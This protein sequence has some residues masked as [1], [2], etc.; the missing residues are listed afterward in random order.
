MEFEV[1]GA[2]RLWRC[3]TQRNHGAQTGAFAQAWR[4]NDSWA[5]LDHFRRNKPVE[6]ANDYGALFGME[7]N[8]HALFYIHIFDIGNCETH[9]G[10]V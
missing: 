3:S 5:A 2:N 8:S 7:L 6:V 1:V 4:H 9:R 10:A